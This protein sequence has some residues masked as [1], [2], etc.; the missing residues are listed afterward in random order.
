MILVADRRCL[1]VQ[2]TCHT[3]APQPLQQPRRSLSRWLLAPSPWQRWVTGSG[4]CLERYQV[5]LWDLL[6]LQASRWISQL[7]IVQ[8][9]MLWSAWGEACWLLRGLV[10]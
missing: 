10:S 1:P 7:L 5:A 6:L 3:T 2:A 9:T 4:C 8:V